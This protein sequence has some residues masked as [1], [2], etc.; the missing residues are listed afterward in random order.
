VETHPRH[1]HH[2]HSRKRV[3]PVVLGILDETPFYMR[4]GPQTPKCTGCH[5]PLDLAAYQ[6]GMTGELACKCGQTMTTCPVPDWLHEVEPKAT[7]L[8]NVAIPD[9]APAPTVATAAA[10]PVSFGCPDCGANSKVTSESPRVLE[11]LYCKVDLF[12]P[13]ALWRALHPV[14]KRGAWYIAF[15]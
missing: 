2:D 15:G 11:C 7:Q 1:A 14:K 13:D 5:E 4:V 12:I 6:P 8:F 9:A 10:R 3:A